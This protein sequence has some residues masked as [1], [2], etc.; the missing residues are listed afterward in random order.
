QSNT[1]SSIVTAPDDLQSVVATGGEPWQHPAMNYSGNGPIA[2]LPA[3]RGQTSFWL[4]RTGAESNQLRIKWLKPVL[5]GFL[6]WTAV[7]LFLAAPD[8]LKGFVWYD[9][10]AKIIDAWS[11]AL[12]T[13]PLLLF[14]RKFASKEQN[15]A[16]LVLLYLLLSVPVS[17]IHT[18][19]TA[20]FLYPIPQVWW[21]PLRNYDFGIFYF[22]GSWETYCAIVGIFYAFKFY[23]RF[24]TG[25]LRLERVERSLIE[26]RLNALRLQLEPHFLF[27]ALNAIS[28]ELAANPAL[29]RE[30]IGN[31]G[32][33][34]RQSLDCKDKA[35]IT[36]AQELALLD[37]Y[38]SIQRVRFGDRIEIRIEVKPE[39]LSAM[40]PS[41]LLQPLVENSIRHGLE[42]RISGGTIV[43]SASNRA[44]HLR[45]DVVDNGVGL[46]RGWEMNK[47]SGHGLRVTRERLNALYPGSDGQSLIIGRRTGGG[48]K[49]TV[50]IPLHGEGTDRHAIGA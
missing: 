25:Q 4:R 23:N 17:L 22:L 49:V 19:L 38:L 46:P 44:D 47:S 6:V 18:Y 20:I 5:T 24:L 45:L 21:S 36:L 12:L 13:P 48:T 8:M 31:L 40:V 42:G 10:V 30:M 33:L 34:L 26:S 43:I 7:G 2:A 16:R 41:M 32:T 3:Q 28:S 14:D 9:T 29:A 1:G 15:P 27:N 11:W 35:E 39:T 37:Q 50:L